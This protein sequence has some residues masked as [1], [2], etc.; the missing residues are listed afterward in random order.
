MAARRPSK[1]KDTTSN[2][3]ASARAIQSLILLLGVTLVL[4][5]FFGACWGPAVSGVLVVATTLPPMRRTVDKW[6]VGKVR[7]DEA[8]QSAIIRMAVGALIVV[9]ALAGIF[10]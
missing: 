4:S 9:L 1:Q 3:P 5:V 8:N 10:G 2:N 6:L 7:G